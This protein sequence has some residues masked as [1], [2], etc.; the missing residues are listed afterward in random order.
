MKISEIR[1]QN[2]YSG[3]GITK[4]PVI[5]W[6][7]E[8]ESG[9]RYQTAC[10]ITVK[11]GSRPV[12]DSGILYTEVHNGHCCPVKLETHRQYQVFV[13][14][15]DDRGETEIGRPYSFLSGISEREGWNCQWISNHTASPH[16]LGKTIHLKPGIRFAAL[17]V[18]GVG[19]YVFRINDRLPDDSVLCGSW[20]EFHKH[21]H[22]QTYDVTDLVEVGENMFLMEVGNGWYCEEGQSG[23]YFYTID[24]GYQSFGNCLAGIARLTVT[25][26]D[27]S[28]EEFGTDG[29][30]WASESETV[31][32]NNYGAEDYDA[33]LEGKLK[34]TA[35]VVLGDEEAPKGRLIPMG[36]PPVK[37]KAVYEGVLAKELP[38]GDLLYDFGQ[39]MSGL[40]EVTVKGC[41]GTKINLY[42]VEKV[43]A[44]GDSWKTVDSWCSYI[45]SG[46][47]EECWKPKFTYEAGRYLLI[48]LSSD[49][50][51]KNFPE[52]INVRGYFITGSAKDVGEF[53]CSDHRYMQIHD[54][55]V[56]AIESNMNHVH[57]DCPTIERLGWQEQNHLMAPSIFYT[58]DAASLWDKIAADVRDGQ[59]AEGE[60]DI[61]AGSYPH[62]YGSGL[63]PSIAPRYARF[64]YAGGEGSFWDITPWGSSI[65]LAA[66]EQYRFTGNR[67]VLT[68]NYG[69]SKR[70]VEYLYGKYLDY[71]L[72]YGTEGDVCFLKHG[73]GDWG[74]EQNRGESRENIET[75]YFYRDLA[76]LAETA[77]W[78]G[79]GEDAKRYQSLSMEVL[80]AY[81][82][83]LLLWNPQTGE[84]AYDSYDKTGFTV[85]QAAQAIPLQFGM[86]PEDKKASVIRSFLLSCEEHRIR[87]GEIGLPYILRTLGDLKQA[88]T[89]RDMVMQ[90]YHPS[91]YRFIEQGETTM[92]EFWR[93]DSRSRNHD[94]M[95][96]V[97][98]WIYRYLAGISSDDGYRTIEIAP[99]LPS[100]VNS[101]QCRYEAITGTVELKLHRIGEEGFRGEV[102]IPVNTRGSLTID[103]QTVPLTGGLTYVWNGKNTG[104]CGREGKIYDL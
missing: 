89:V 77:G 11:E 96:S 71:N 33:R 51:N 102:C 29:S 86:V 31:Y 20:T 104:F 57:T 15:T 12:F 61:D 35:A 14:V 47:G 76:V 3:T 43:N 87:A 91:Y 42:P 66:Y 103:G 48:T 30:W 22:Y 82:R 97:L 52:I 59:Y 93:D 68:A 44:D 62:V 8:K 100:D 23:R 26:G 46:N 45:L 37:V 2:S 81:N 32:T 56:R 5:A 98:E 75:A 72:L 4:D 13:E 1:L 49:S 80:E 17:S 92:P 18:A 54:L 25:Y 50:E 90:K 21:V 60:Q 70:Y 28:M 67:E 7:F 6:K 85:T 19:Q 63:L 40:F 58:K 99:V 78:A 16:Y 94:M 83:A 39:N 27:G 79:Y 74:I 24:K 9:G 73:L 10:R 101:I 36:Y 95:G 84:W 41:R 64:L 38:A 65:L 88:D 69:A 53:S 55:V 34:K